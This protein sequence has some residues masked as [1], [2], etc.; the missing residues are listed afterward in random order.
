MGGSF[1]NRGL[2]KNSIDVAIFYLV[3]QFLS[4]PTYFLLVLPFATC[5]LYF[6]KKVNIHPSL[7]ISLQD[8]SF[9][10]PGLQC[11]CWRSICSCSLCPCSLR[12]CPCSLRPCPCSLRPRSCSLRSRSCSLCSCSCSLQSPLQ[13]SCLP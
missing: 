9:H 1:S 5:T 8:S 6:A 4:L 2:S 11:P 7:I 10:S 12:P 3:R 13:S